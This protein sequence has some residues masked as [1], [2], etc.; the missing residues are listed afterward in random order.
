[1]NKVNEEIA[2]LIEQR[3]AAE[4]AKVEQRQQHRE[5]VRCS[6]D[7]GV[8]PITAAIGKGETPRN[9]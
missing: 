6:A 1:V 5:N 3:R 7:G 8:S 9:C 2:K 4:I